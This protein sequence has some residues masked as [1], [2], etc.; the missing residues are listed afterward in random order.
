LRRLTADKPPAQRERHDS[1]NNSLVTAQDSSGCVAWQA[2]YDTDGMQ[3]CPSFSKLA[4][5]WSIMKKCWAQ[6]TL[7]TSP[8][9]HDV[10]LT[11]NLTN[12]LVKYN[13]SGISAYSQQL[14]LR[15]CKVVVKNLEQTTDQYLIG[16][17]V[18]ATSQETINYSGPFYLAR[19]SIPKLPPILP[20]LL[21]LPHVGT[22]AT[23]LWDT[24]LKTKISFTLIN[25]Q[26]RVPALEEGVPCQGDRK[27]SD[28][29]H[30]A[31]NL[32][33]KAHI[34]LSEAM[35]RS[36]KKLFVFQVHGFS[37]QDLKAIITNGLS[38]KVSNDSF[39][40]AFTNSTYYEYPNA[41]SFVSCSEGTLLPYREG[42]GINQAWM[43]V[44]YETCSQDPQ[45]E[46]GSKNRDT[47]IGMELSS[48][49]NK[50]NFMINRIKSL[51]PYFN[52]HVNYTSCPTP[53]AAPTKKPTSKP[54]KSPTE[55]PTLKPTKSPTKRPT[56]KP[57]EKP[58]RKPTKSPT[59]KPTLRPTKPPTKRPTNKPSGKPTRKP[60]LAV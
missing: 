17:K 37:S 38:R 8:T 31:D 29:T 16:I 45:C 57:T 40:Y 11:M 48:L 15:F 53:T 51:T 34:G 36:G 23:N 22:D 30:N 55:K 33:M 60:R 42:C 54:T 56:S 10:A 6:T 9:P 14:N 28:A 41:T 46:F 50:D 35:Q 3:F 58:T 1:L 47:V 21:E 2:P 43:Q 49:V 25:G 39:M 24:F 32:F 27:K 18:P 5:P 7:Y 19:W 20:V 26:A 13:V 12:A 52:S 44:R 4:G 59:E